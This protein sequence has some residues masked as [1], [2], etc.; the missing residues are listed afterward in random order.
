MLN[1]FIPQEKLEDIV[2]KNMAS[3]TNEADQDVWFK[4]FTKLK[5]IYIS[6]LEEKKYLTTEDT[7]FLLEESYG[8]EIKYATKYID[9]ISDHPES[10][11]QYQNGIFLLDIS[12]EDAEAIQRDYG[13]ICQSIKKMDYSVLMDPDLKFSL[14]KKDDNYTW[15]SM[16]ERIDAAHIPSNHLIMIDRYLFANEKE[17]GNSLDNIYGILDAMLP[18][19]KLKCPY[20]VSIIIGEQQDGKGVALSYAAHKVYDMTSELDRPYPIDVEVFYHTHDSGLYSRTH[21]RY[22]L[23]NYTITNAGYK[24]NAFDDDN[25]QCMQPIYV[26]GL[27]SINGLDGYCDSP[28]KS[29]NDLMLAIYNHLNWWIKHPTT[30]DCLSAYNG[31]VVPINNIYQS[32]NQIN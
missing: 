5:Y 11:T 19:H 20:K 21:N 4:I 30:E 15:Y 22:I 18:T 10:V 12:E 8:I 7:L 24:L 3:S 26:Q 2:I 23:T 32:K 29:H 31:N 16:L 27:F 28:H 1:V 6:S 9:S 13:V 14:D 25:S 17:L